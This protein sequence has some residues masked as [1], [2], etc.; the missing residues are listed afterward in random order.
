MARLLIEGFELGTVDHWHKDNRRDRD[1]S[2]AMNIPGMDGV[3][4]FRP[5]NSYSLMPLSSTAA[6]VYVSF[7]YRVYSAGYNDF[8]LGF[9]ASD[10]AML[11]CLVKTS[12]N[13]LRACRGNVGT[14]LATGS[15]A[16]S[17]NVTY[18]ITIVFT[19][20]DTSGVFQVY[21]DGGGTPEINF[22]GDSSDN[23]DNVA[24]IG[25]GTTGASSYGTHH[26]LDNLVVDDAALPGA[27]KIRR[28]LPDGSGN[29]DAWS[30]SS[31][32][33]F[34]GDPE[35]VSLW[36]LEPGAMETDSI[37]NVSLTGVNTPDSETTAG[38][39]KEGSG[40]AKVDRSE[41]E[42]FYVNDSALPTGYPLKNGDTVKKL[43]FALWY[44]PTTVPGASQYH[45]IVSKWH[46][47]NSKLTFSLLL[48][49]GQLR[50]GWG[51]G[52]G[53]NAENWYP[54]S[55]SAGR[56][57]HLGCAIDGIAKTALIRL[58]DDT[59]QS[60]ATYT[61]NFTNELRI[62]DTSYTFFAE[63]AGNNA[64][65]RG[66]EIAFFNDIKTESDFDSMRQG[67]YCSVKHAVVAEVPPGAGDYIYTNTTGDKQ[68]FTLGAPPSNIDTVHAVMTA[69]KV[70]ATGN[71][72][73]RNVKT[74]MRTH[75]TDYDGSDVF[76]PWMTPGSGR[77][78][79]LVNPNTGSAFTPE[80]LAALEVGVKAAT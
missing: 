37:G 20:H 36:R 53:Q 12:S 55:I 69:I 76:A 44:R 15:T 14:T 78:L 49:N 58:W 6:T 68:L 18:R 45:G 70:K 13:Y 73:P 65:G 4:C 61:H 9:H 48:E 46:W 54:C 2:F 23:T 39:F 52:T 7:L 35:C 80:E 11:A 42:Y 3:Y 8:L 31:G 56:W 71:T 1:E 29:S 25:I 75:G 59:A 64:D 41:S 24:H 79:Y 50:L 60:A 5:N 67:T 19:P 72:A 63:G 38:M 33:N 40:C 77:E 21:I 47:T 32:N 51:Y 16:L 26:Y 57:Y 30:A 28:M 66:D 27:T 43:S 62:C 74:V 34:A 10:G 22:S 17:A